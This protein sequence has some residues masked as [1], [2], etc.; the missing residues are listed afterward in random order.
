MKS[1]ILK[2][3][4]AGLSSIS[5]TR[6]RCQLYAEENEAAKENLIKNINQNN[7]ELFKDLQKEIPIRQNIDLVKEIKISAVNQNDDTNVLTE[8]SDIASDKS[9]IEADGSTGGLS[10]E[11][12][13]RS[14]ECILVVGTT[15]TGKS[16]TISKYTG[17]NCT[18]SDGAHSATRQCASFPDCRG[19]H[20]PVWV[21]TRG[22]DDS[23]D[24]SDQDSYRD[25][26][27]FL[28]SERL[29]K[30]KAIVW[31]VNSQERKDARLRRQADF[32]NQFKD[33]EIWDNVIIVVK[34]PVSYNLKQGSQGA[35]E[36][37]KYYA[38]EFS[39]LQVLGFT[40]LDDKIPEHIRSKLLELGPEERHERLILT[41]A[42]VVQQI[43]SALRNID[44]PVQVIFE[45]K[46]CTACGI[47]GDKRLLPDFCHLEQ[48]FRHAGKLK[49][50]HP[51]EIEGYHPRPLQS[52]HSG[53]L[54]LVG[55]KNK[56]CETVKNA[57]FWLTPAVGVVDIFT[58][59]GTAALA[60]TTAYV[61]RQLDK[62]Y[63]EIYSCCG[64]EKH[65]AGCKVEYACC[66][67]VESSY[68]CC[69]RYP[70]CQGGVQAPGCTRRYECCG[71]EEEAT[72]CES[73]CKKCGQAWG[74]ATRDCFRTEH[75]L[76]SYRP[77]SGA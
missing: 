21:D 53:V 5:Y 18:V 6:Y 65:S 7:N 12:S 68:G 57:L 9:R 4:L 1:K 50:Y 36:A 31:T 19:L 71:R 61:C 73:I 58:G 46:Q 42:E 8:T 74:S 47:I 2:L 41:D 77:D 70:C 20:L 22:Y 13:N 17:Q 75:Q 29:L 30:V 66:K 40:Y 51:E 28:S 34:S 32:I 27:K 33:I 16:S 10:E 62:P 11:K 37:A 67:G 15:G 54:K 14:C 55:G 38:G 56:E 48:G 3:G 72:G 76:I 59:L 26:L 52:T 63:A 39:K 60:G 35:Q 25:L 23:A 64:G 44:A 43:D 24:L 49:H 45:D 69:E